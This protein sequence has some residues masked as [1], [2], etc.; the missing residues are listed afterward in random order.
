MSLPYL[1]RFEE[2]EHE[3]NAPTGTLA[4]RVATSNLNHLARSHGQV[5][6]NWA[7]GD[8]NG[9]QRDT[10]GPDGARGAWFWSSGLFPLRMRPDGTAF[11]LRVRLRGRRTTAGSAA[12]FYVYINASGGFGG[13][14]ELFY[15]TSTTGDW[16]DPDGS[17][18]ISPTTD[19]TNDMT[20]NLSTPLTLGGASVAFPEVMARVSVRCSGAADWGVQELTGLHVAEFYG[21]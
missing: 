3:E 15:T 14:R 8:G 13:D 20:D 11:P 7:V 10:D 6:V 21:A 5:L 4:K 16:I 12:I 18:L 9:V 1:V 17:G 19:T 2:S